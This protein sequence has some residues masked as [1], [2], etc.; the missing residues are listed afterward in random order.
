MRSPA[1][2]GRLAGSAYLG[3]EGTGW[4]AFV[5]TAGG[6]L[7][8]HWCAI[9]AACPAP[10]P[11]GQ[12]WAG[13]GARPGEACRGN[14]GPSGTVHAVRRRAAWSLLNAKPA[15]RERLRRATPLI[16]FALDVLWGANDP[17]KEDDDDE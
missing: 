8:T 14:H 6:Y 13:C 5:P 4:I 3:R 16:A 11:H 1:V 17:T 7:K 12:L 2:H 9:V 15:A 10:Q